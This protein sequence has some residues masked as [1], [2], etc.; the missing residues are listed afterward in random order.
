MARMWCREVDCACKVLVVRAWLPDMD[1]RAEEGRMLHQLPPSSS[2]A[3]SREM[4]LAKCC[5][6]N[7]VGQGSWLPTPSLVYHLHLSHHG[8]GSP[9]PS[10]MHSCLGVPLVGAVSPRRP[11]PERKTAAG[12]RGP[13]VQE[14]APP[15]VLL[16]PAAEN[17]PLC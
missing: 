3:Q 11:R 10:L 16:G 14:A 9:A 13:A 2:L 8:C 4:L 17:Q 12:P 15:G 7:A 6:P 5:W 1:A